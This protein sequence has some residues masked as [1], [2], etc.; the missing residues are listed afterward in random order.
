ML[1]PV[2]VTNADRTTV[3]TSYNPDGSVAQTSG[4]RVYAAGNTYDWQGRAKT[5]TT[6]NNFNASNPVGPAVTTWNYD[7]YRGWLIS[8]LDN[9]GKGPAYAYTHGGR[10]NI[11]TWARGTNLSR[12]KGSPCLCV[13][14]GLPRRSF[15]PGFDCHGKISAQT[16]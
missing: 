7:P 14:L 11:R 16:R 10:L 9:N 12:S 4:S 1:R 2:T 3:N 15:G 13:F 8:K 5:L 6:W